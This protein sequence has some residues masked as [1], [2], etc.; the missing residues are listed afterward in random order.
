MLLAIL[1]GVCPN[2]RTRNATELLGLLLGSD[3]DAC[4]SF[5]DKEGE[6][7]DVL[8]GLREGLG[9]E[10]MLHGIDLVSFR[11][12]LLLLALPLLGFQGILLFLE[13]LKSLSVRLV[14]FLV[15]D[16]VYDGHV[17][18]DGGKLVAIG[19]LLLLIK[20]LGLLLLFIGFLL[21]DA[22]LA[23]LAF[24]GDVH[25]VDG[26]VEEGNAA[27][28]GVE[29][30]AGLTSER[31]PI[32]VRVGAGFGG[33]LF[34]ELVDETDRVVAGN[35]LAQQKRIAGRGVYMYQYHVC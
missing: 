6:V 21:D 29:T 8:H 33:Q 28:D 9:I 32:E 10:Q 17:A 16:L 27:G 18:L 5:L 35:L 24:L 25:D 11:L 20:L 23:L 31:S 30:D 7:E 26:A 22:L 1:A 12:D 34:T 2:D 3:G 13:G 14:A 15:Q 4:R 19:L